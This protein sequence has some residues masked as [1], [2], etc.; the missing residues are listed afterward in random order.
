MEKER[1]QDNGCCCCECRE[2]TWQEVIAERITDEH[3][4]EIVLGHICR[5]E[6][7]VEEKEREANERFKMY[8]GLA[9][10]LARLSIS[11]T[12]VKRSRDEIDTDRS[13]MWKKQ[14]YLN[15]IKRKQ[16]K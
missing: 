3:E 2:K 8:V 5:L 6:T 11:F 4:L 14:Y 10:E 12:D 13:F 9:E 7:K 15:E 16:G 1:P